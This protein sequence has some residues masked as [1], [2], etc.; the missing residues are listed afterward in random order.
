MFKANQIPKNASE[1]RKEGELLIEKLLQILPDDDLSKKCHDL[2]KEYEQDT[3]TSYIGYVQFIKQQIE[4]YSYPGYYCFPQ[5]N[6]WLSE[7]KKYVEK[8]V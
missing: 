6:E 4:K 2:K 8:G 5:M 3:H 1:D 7:A